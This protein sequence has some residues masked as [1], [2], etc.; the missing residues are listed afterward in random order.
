MNNITYMHEHMRINLSGI[1][2]DLDCDLNCFDDT[3]NE[4]KKLKTLGVSNIV[5]V[6]NIGMGR[7]VDFMRRLEK[8]SGIRL[9][10]STGFYKEPFLPQFFYEKTVGELA[11]LMVDELTCGIDG[12]DRKA[13]VIGEVGTSSGKMTE[14][15]KK[16]F[17]ASCIAHKKT[18]AP[19]ST[20]T[21][22]GTFATEQGEFFIENKV[23]PAR[24]YIGHTDLSKNVETVSN[25]ISKG[26]YCGF[27]TVGKINYFVDEG[28]CEMLKELQNRNQLDH[29]M[30]SMDITRKSHLG[31][32]GGLSYSY[33]IEKF[34]PLMLSYGISEK[35][36]EKM[37]IENPARF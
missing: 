24:V 26:F 30:L 36:I 32:N 16:L 29:V 12:T 23:D 22:I 13:E 33:I 25:L 31:V 6:T 2:K 17:L 37:L 21:T 27:D 7:D 34:V 35:S 4:L 5:E 20:H 1:K 18:Q 14:E 3:L 11:E 9:I 10:M 19:I 28:R 8:E 15:E